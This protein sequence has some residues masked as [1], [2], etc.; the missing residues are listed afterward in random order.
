MQTL[1]RL[2]RVKEKK[3]WEREVGYLTPLSLIPFLVRQLPGNLAG[4]WCVENRSLSYILAHRFSVR[5][6]SHRLSRSFILGGIPKDTSIRFQREPS[7]SYLFTAFSMSLQTR[8]SLSTSVLLHLHKSVHQKFSFVL[9]KNESIEGDLQCLNLCHAACIVLKCQKFI[10]NVAKAANDEVNS[11]MKVQAS[12]WIKRWGTVSFFSFYNDLLQARHQFFF[13]FFSF[14]GG[15]SPAG[16]E[17][18]HCNHCVTQQHTFSP[19]G[20]FVANF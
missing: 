4:D 20:W 5:D 19:L 16:T 11:F 13:Q 3:K 14:L 6:E 9:S 10:L 7:Q 1:Q 15:S 12:S 17:Q 2:H 8:L 18:N